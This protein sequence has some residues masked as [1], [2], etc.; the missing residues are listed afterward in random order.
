MDFF[1]DIFGNEQLTR[2]L[3]ESALSG[4]LPHALILEGAQGS[5]KKTAAL[6]AVCTAY[7]DYAEKIRAGNCPDVMRMGAEEGRKS[8][9]VEQIR[10]LRER[11][12]LAPN[13]LDR[14]FFLIEG[15][16]T[17]TPQAQNAL[18]KILEEPP[19]DVYIF[20]LCESVSPLLPTV[21]SRAPVMRMQAFDEQE[22]ETFFSADKAA[23]A[24]REKDP[25]G[26]LYALHSCAGSIGLARR[27]M[28]SRSAKGSMELFGRVSGFY[29]A[30]AGGSKADFCLLCYG[31][32]DT[33]DELGLFLDSAE[34]AL[35]DLL[36]IK[37]CLPKGK[38]P[39]GAQLLFFTDPQNGMELAGQ[40]PIAALLALCA[41][42]LTLHESLRANVNLKTA[43]TVFAGAA[44][45]SVHQ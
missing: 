12:S 14:K 23:R 9:G 1:A 40:I 28:N 32:A 39:A 42:M 29:A 26:Y 16:E 10:Q 44:W 13:D 3:R 43:L 19:A 34:E 2:Y 15:A 27:R 36:Y 6:A 37:G 22:L 21:L 38:T 35:R 4:S 30:L 31:A 8:I 11:A 41:P 45:E 5:G 18:L 20:L 17:M 24:F 25:E 7:P 33:R